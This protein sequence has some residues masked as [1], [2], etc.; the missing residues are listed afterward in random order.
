MIEAPTDEHFQAYRFFLRLNVRMFTMLLQV[1]Q[2]QLQKSDNSAPDVTGQLNKDNE[3]FT[4]LARRILPGIRLYSTWL[5]GRAAIVVEQSKNDQLTMYIATMWQTYADTLSLIVSNYHAD[6]LLQVDY[7]LEEDEETIGFKPFRE[8]EDCRH[9]L[10]YEGRL[11]PCAAHPAYPSD[12]GPQRNHP[13]TEMLS[14]VR[15]ILRIGL[16][17]STDGMYPINMVDGPAFVYTVP[18]VTGAQSQVAENPTPQSNGNETVS[19]EVVP[20]NYDGPVNEPETVE[21]SSTQLDRIEDTTPDGEVPQHQ[22][23]SRVSSPAVSDSCQSMS[24]SGEMYRMVDDLTT[25]TA[26]KDFRGYNGLNHVKEASYEARNSTNYELREQHKRGQSGSSLRGSG[27]LFFGHSPFAP[28]PG[29]VPLTGREPKMS[30][31]GRSATQS[32]SPSQANGHSGSDSGDQWRQKNGGPVQVDTPSRSQAQP[33]DAE[34][35]LQKYQ[36]RPTQDLPSSNFTDNSSI[37]HG[38]PAHVNS[39]SWANVT[40]AF[41]QGQHRSAYYTGG[42]GGHFPVPSMIQS[43]LWDGS[44]PAANKYMATPPGGQGG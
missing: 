24:M 26:A 16:Q 14:R 39:L 33:T 38:T 3:T 27:D 11:K 43:S 18:E 23:F 40:N 5:L 2:P 6:D 37:Y 35:N 25:P 13:N 10:D 44:Q 19:W 41:G 9:Y 34:I 20:Y 4:V 31:F 1:Y 15:D 12:T 30:R 42:R 22:L 32:T 17:L 29:E 21:D 7:L 8:I 36:Y 28:L